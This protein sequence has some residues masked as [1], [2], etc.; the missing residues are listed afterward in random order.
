MNDGTESKPARIFVG[1]KVAADIA[2]QLATM[3]AELKET[4]ARLVARSDIHLTLVPPWQES[5]TEQAVERLRDVARLFLSLFLKFEH[6][7]YGPHPRRP[8]LLWA[9]CAA[10]GELA[11]LRNALLL[12]FE[13]RDDRPFRP[14][15]TLAR[16]RDAQPS[17]ARR[18]PI[19]RDLNFTQ[20]VTTVELFQSPPPGATGYRVLAS[21]ELGGA[22]TSAGTDGAPDLDSGQ[23]AGPA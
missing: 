4:P 12:A 3:A 7:G 14:H 20:A 15:V 1:L 9:D 10:T 6:L 23:G 2:D 11:T 16:I 19:D 17:F 5:S 21:V 8:R 13:Q 22:P 18:H